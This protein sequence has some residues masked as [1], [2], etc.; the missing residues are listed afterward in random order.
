MIRSHV[1]VVESSLRPDQRVKI[2]SDSVIR[3]CIA[4]LPE[5]PDKHADA[6]LNSVI[7]Q[8]EERY[9][10]ATREEVRALKHRMTL[11]SKEY[12]SAPCEVSAMKLGE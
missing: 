6:E 8:I 7:T 3:S 9:A 10:A 5:P 12:R 11:P 1:G 4:T 2:D